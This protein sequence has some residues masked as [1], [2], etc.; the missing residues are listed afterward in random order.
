[1]KIPKSFV[2]ALSY[3]LTLYGERL[4]II[5]SM[6]LCWQLIVAAMAVFIF[7]LFP[8]LSMN[9]HVKFICAYSWVIGNCFLLIPYLAL[10]PKNVSNLL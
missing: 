10:R 2:R 9:Y 4:V 1:M 5:D 7:F 8:R 6:E 3:H